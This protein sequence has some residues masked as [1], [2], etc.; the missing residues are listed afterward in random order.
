MSRSI[1]TIPWCLITTGRGRERLPKLTETDGRG[2]T[3]ET[4]VLGPTPIVVTVQAMDGRRSPLQPQRR[5]PHTPNES[6]CWR[7]RSRPQGLEVKSLNVDR[8]Q[9]IVR[10][11]NAR[12]VPSR[13]ERLVIR[14]GTYC[15]QTTNG[16]PVSRTWH[17]SN[18]RNIGADIQKG[19]VKRRI[20]TLGPL[21]VRVFIAVIAFGHPSSVV[22]RGSR[23]RHP[24]TRS[25]H[26]P[27]PARD[28][29]M[30]LYQLGILTPDP[31]LA[32]I[33]NVLNIHLKVSLYTEGIRRH[34]QQELPK[35]FGHLIITWTITS[36]FCLGQ[37][38]GLALLRAHLH[39]A[40]VSSD[41]WCS[42]SR[43][44]I[45]FSRAETDG[46]DLATFSARAKI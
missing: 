42:T 31:S 37:S 11:V 35:E 2:K 20:R 32:T 36:V 33:L 34:G 1:G 21:N 5:M 17:S 9:S 8:H 12:K 43:S 29:R 28:W 27:G 25:P 40:I 10:I 23:P 46:L 14:P 16:T 3:T 39:L 22:F 6:P 4:V 24:E 13:E 18:L 44:Y 7:S 45:R 19:K 41:L 15:L 26:L 38:L 30:K